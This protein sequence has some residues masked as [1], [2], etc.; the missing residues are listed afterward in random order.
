MNQ[1]VEKYLGV[2]WGEIRIGLALA[3]SETKLATPFRVAKSLKE[4]LAAIKE[5]E[6][7]KIIIGAPKKMFDSKLRMSN[8]Y[9][10]FLDLLKS[11]VKIPVVEVDERLSSQAA[12]SLVGDK[13]TKA[14]R[15][16]LAAMLILQS[17]LDRN[18]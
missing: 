12:D 2:D 14:P 3:D 5:E 18:T 4:V 6:I 17:F 16:A 7:D 8:D 13:K 11:K 1:E 15:D 9:L 10:K